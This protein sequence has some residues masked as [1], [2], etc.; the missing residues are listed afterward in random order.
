MAEGWT[1]SLKHDVIEAFSA[2]IERHG[3][4]PAAVQVMKEAGV[5]ITA[6][7]CKLIEELED[8]DYD[9]VITVCDKARESCPY[10]PGNAVQIHVGF[11]DPPSLAPDAGSEKER[12]RH[13]RRVRDEIKR[14]VEGLP[15]SLAEYSRPEQRS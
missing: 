12:L 4:D 8:F 10:F 15:E 9:Y 14:F 7:R 11:D 1:R 5:D 2:G 3:L 6:Q 13:Y